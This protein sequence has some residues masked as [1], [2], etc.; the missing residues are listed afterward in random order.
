[1][2][3]GVEIICSCSSSSLSLSSSSLA[4]NR[5]RAWSTLMRERK[6]FRESW[7][8]LKLVDGAEKDFGWVRP[9]RLRGFGEKVFLLHFFFLCFFCG[10]VFQKPKQTNWNACGKR[11][12]DATFLRGK[13]KRKSTQKN[14]QGN[15]KK[16]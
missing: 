5:A 8:L 1:M 4:F 14:V 15:G 10:V 13:K 12:F 3:H 7:L 2:L 9:S 6:F 11:N 16:T